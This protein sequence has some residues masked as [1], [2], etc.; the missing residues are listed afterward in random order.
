VLTLQNMHDQLIANV[1]VLQAKGIQ[2]MEND[3]LDKTRCLRD[4]E[5]AEGL[6]RTR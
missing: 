3:E 1:A 2:L 6:D 5:R 4:Y